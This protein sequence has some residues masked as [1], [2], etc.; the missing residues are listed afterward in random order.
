MCKKNSLRCVKIRLTWISEGSI[1]ILEPKFLAAS[2]ELWKSTTFTQM[3]PICSSINWWIFSFENGKFWHTA[4]KAILRKA[5]LGGLSTHLRNNV[6]TLVSITI[7]K[8]GPLRLF[9]VFETTPLFPY[10]EMRERSYLVGAYVLVR[11]FNVY[12]SKR[13][14]KLECFIMWKSLFLFVSL[15]KMFVQLAFLSCIYR[16]F[17]FTSF[18]IMIKKCNPSLRNKTIQMVLAR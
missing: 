5:A 12:I 4:H 8:Q 15:A 11:R 6:G 9:S 14:N 3:E 16:H 1:F 7:R 2:K 10:Q 18:L 13:T 17:V